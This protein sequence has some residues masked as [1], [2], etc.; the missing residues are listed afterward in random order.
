MTDTTENPFPYTISDSPEGGQIHRA[1]LAVCRDI[2]A[3][4][5][6]GTLELGGKSIA[7][8]RIDDIRDA[9]K[10]IMER[11]GI[12]SYPQLIE[13]DLQRQVAQEPMTMVQFDGEKNLLPGREIRDGKIP[14]TRSWATVTMALRFV[15]VGDNSQIVVSA[16]GEAYDTNGDKAT[17]KATTAAIKRI[18]F[19]TFKIT[20]RKEGDEE[21]RDPEAGNRAATTD[22][23]EGGDRGQQSRTAAQRVA[24]TGTTRRTSGAKAPVAVDPATPTQ[25]SDAAVA[26]VDTSTGEVPDEQPAP[27]APKEPSKLD[28]TK[29]RVRDAVK[30]LKERDGQE[31]WSTAQV[32]AIATELTGKATR[33]E[34]INSIQAVTKLAVALESN[35]KGGA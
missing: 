33:P 20:D 34:W 11:H 21:E 31:S 8:T 23:R 1:I 6:D 18:L 3:V 30:A 32:D 2:P 9:M 16:P 13:K 5:K 26:A 17:A 29:G 14:T 35:L 19:E 12:V 10:P 4:S 28:A 27:Q 15:F 25:P 22:R 24:G 7:F